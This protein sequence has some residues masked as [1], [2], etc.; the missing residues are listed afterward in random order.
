MNKMIAFSRG[1]LRKMKKGDWFL[2]DRVSAQIGGT[3]Y[4]ENV[5]IKITKLIVVN[6][7]NPKDSFTVSKVV[8]L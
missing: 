4:S 2:T 8:K 6:P 1:D 3:A 7:L 5:K